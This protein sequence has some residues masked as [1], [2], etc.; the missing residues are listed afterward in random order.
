MQSKS[1]MRGTARNGE[2]WLEMGQGLCRVLLNQ[3]WTSG[4]PQQGH[5]QALSSTVYH[6]SSAAPKKS[7]LSE[8]RLRYVYSHGKHR[9]RRS[10]LSTGITATTRDCRHS[11]SWSV[12]SMHWSLVTSRVSQYDSPCVHWQSPNTV[13]HRL[14]RI[15]ASTRLEPSLTRDSNF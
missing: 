11:T 5:S 8:Q 15:Y 10:V 13:G 2:E 7:R 14:T 3:R 12:D 9:Q 4:G 1:E 6:W